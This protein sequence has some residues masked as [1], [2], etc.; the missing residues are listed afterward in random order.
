M[1]CTA[2]GVA[3]FFG[4]SDVSQKH[5]ARSC[6]KDLR[7]CSKNTRIFAYKF[8]VCLLERRTALES[9]NSLF[10]QPSLSDSENAKG[11]CLMK[12]TLRLAYFMGGS[13]ASTAL[14]MSNRPHFA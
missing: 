13:A 3:A 12:A 1:Y 14:N 6:F 10:P 2:T 4:A 9:L 7:S 5:L 8:V 11:D